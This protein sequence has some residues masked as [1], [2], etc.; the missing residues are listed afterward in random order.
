MVKPATSAVVAPVAAGGAA[1]TGMSAGDI[2][3]VGISAACVGVLADEVIRIIKESL[4]DR[5][6][7]PN[8]K[9]QV[10]AIDNL[11]TKKAATQSRIAAFY[12]IDVI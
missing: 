5:P 7:N 8:A 11:H 3:A 6:D 12:M 9:I 1:T 2:V 4:E 10:L